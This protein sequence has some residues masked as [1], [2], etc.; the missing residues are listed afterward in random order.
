MF[1]VELLSELQSAP[2]LGIDVHDRA[3]VDSLDSLR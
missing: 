3:A 2:A 1:E